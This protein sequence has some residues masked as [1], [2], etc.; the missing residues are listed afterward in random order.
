M[1]YEKLYK[2]YKTSTRNVMK[3]L[4]VYEK[5]YNSLIDIYAGMLAQYEILNQRIIDSNLNIEVETQRGGNRK[6]ALATATEKLRDQIILY[7]DRLLINPKALN[8]NNIDTGAKEPTSL[9]I[10][11]KALERWNNWTKLKEGSY[12]MKWLKS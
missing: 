12:L 9:E 3:A 5:E 1:E 8:K 11:L 7:T 10:A 6:S 4:N 2:K